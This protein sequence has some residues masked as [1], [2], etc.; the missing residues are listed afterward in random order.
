MRHAAAILLLLAGASPV[1]AADKLPRVPAGF[2]IEK[3]T[4]PDLVKHPMMAGFDDRGRLFV[5]CSAG[6]NVRAADLMKNPPN[7]IKMLEDTNGDG[8]FDKATVFADKMTLPMGALWYRGALYVASPPHI[9]KLEDT[10]DDG[11]ADK[12]T[13]LVDRFGFSGNAASVHG[14]FLGPTGRIY[15]CDGRHGHEFKD[16]HGKIISKG[17]AARIFSCKPDGS[18]V[19]VHCGGGMDNPVEIDFTETGEMIGSVNLFYGRPRGDCLV[20]WVEGGVYPRH[21]QQQCIEEFKRTGD[22]LGPIKN[23]G[24]VAVSGM[25]R[26]RSDQFGKQYQNNIFTTLFNT[27]KVIRSEL[28]RSGSTFTSTEHEFLTSDNPDFHPTDVF[29]DADGSLLVIDT[30]GWFRIG[31]PVSKVAKPDIYGAIYRIRKTGSHKVDDP[32]GLK[33]GL[34][35]MPAKELV[36]Y[37]DDP[38]PAVREKAIDRLAL[39]GRQSTEAMFALFSKSSR[40]SVL[41][42]RNAVWANARMKKGAYGPILALATFVNQHPSV[43][44]AGVHTWCEQGN[45]MS[46]EI[47]SDLATGKSFAIRREV[48]RWMGAV[49]RREHVN[50]LFALMKMP[51]NDRVTEHTIIYSLIQI[52]ERKATLPFLKDENPA[53]RRAALI[54]LDQ[55]N[56]G[57]LTRE[58]VT[59]LLDTDDEALRNTALAIISKHDGW[60][61][62]TLT[63]IRKWLNE[64]A[65]REPGRAAPRPQRAAALRGFLIAQ[66]NDKAVQALV[67]EMLQSPE[68]T[69]AKRQLLLEVVQ[70]ASLETFP[71]A[72]TEAIRTSLKSTNVGVKL[73]AVRIVGQRRLPLV[74]E[75]Q[76]ISFFQKNPIELR[77]EA[78]LAV[79][80]SIKA[81]GDRQLFDFIRQVN[82]RKPV[83]TR[84]TIARAIAAAP[85]TDRQ[86]IKAHAAVATSDPLTLPV[87]LRAFERSKSEEV[88]LSLVEAL[89][90]SRAI[91]SISPGELQRVLRRYPNS[92]REAAKPLLAKLGVNPAEQQQQI[93]A[94]L[95][96]TSGGD[97]KRG[98]KVFFS[99]KA[100]C[101]GCHTV[102]GKGGRVGPDL[103][104]IGRIRQDRDL[105]EAIAFPSATL[106]RGFR[107]YVIAT[108]RG[109]VH[110]G[111]ITRE[112]SNEII[113]RDAALAEIRIPRKSIEAIRESPTSI[114]PKGLDKTLTTAELRDLLAFLKSRKE[115]A[116]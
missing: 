27:H 32:R 24:H 59:P 80:P 36:K 69:V 101:A 41:A 34:G 94:L 113:L 104:A 82:S 89:S 43:Q 114:M 99:K 23:L 62:E 92:V 55:M 14:C 28:K 56:D 72:W 103:S 38:R 50:N 3:V 37:L 76:V 15:W 105:V 49:R 51:G 4:T 108:D 47:D 116:K 20:H 79:G 90:A 8:K 106:A 19:R 71:D 84:L 95:K 110:T 21:D 35:K 68:T 18:D 60:A 45:L 88:G 66:A 5:A 44:L 81:I 109:K 54:A 97:A 93:A 57:N 75:T 78:L 30:G 40:A 96:V 85:L 6:K 112:T 10:D 73:Q 29:E 100:A 12:R 70:R 13:I 2:T 26:Y 42:R 61:K 22:L 9:W 53:V 67:A 63:L 87:L 52:G 64:Q 65:T 25:T 11:V 107:S 98:R 77:A 17:K 91:K 31:C 1:A 48:A 111:L 39:L 83:L 58:L 74:T 86:L 33:L 16:K 102:A 46:S 7:F 115:P